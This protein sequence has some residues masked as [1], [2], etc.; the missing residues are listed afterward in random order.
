MKNDNDGDEMQMNIDIGDSGHNESKKKLLEDDMRKM[1]EN[2][3][4]S[5]TKINAS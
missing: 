3:D 1:T 2:E 5:P 4:H